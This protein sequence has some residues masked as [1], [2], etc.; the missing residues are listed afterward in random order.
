MEQLAEVSGLHGLVARD[1][2]EVFAKLI[3]DDEDVVI[4]FLVFWELFEVDG[5]VLVWLVRD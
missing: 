5:E 3:N 4:T 2:F 1:G